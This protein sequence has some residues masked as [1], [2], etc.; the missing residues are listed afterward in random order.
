MN[1][2]RPVPASVSPPIRSLQKAW[3]E[4]Y[5][6]KHFKDRSVMI[7]YIDQGLRN[8]QDYDRV[9][10]FEDKTSSAKWLLPPDWQYLLFEDK[11]YKGRM[12]R[13]PGTGNVSSNSDF[14]GW[15]D[16]VSSSKFAK[17]NITR[18]QEAW[19]ELYDDRNFKDRR[20]TILGGS[21]S[22][23]IKN[24]KKIRVEGKGGFGDKVSSVRWQ[25]P[26]G[27]TYRLYEHDSYRGKTINLVGTGT[28][29]EIP[30]LRSKGFNDKVSSSRYR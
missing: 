17:K 19:I 24:Y 4:L 5:D 10:G 9:D 27:Y 23:S 11:H 30:N 12:M 22:T 6:D 21:S 16:M 20:L 29:K 13:L 18:I 1:E 28:I 8:Y 3:I 26:R 14:K 7:D 15:N 25:I 2:F